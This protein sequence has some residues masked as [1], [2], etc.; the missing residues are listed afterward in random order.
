LGKKKRR[1]LVLGEEGKRGGTRKLAGGKEMH[2]SKFEYP[3][4]TSERDNF[5]IW[6]KKLPLAGRARQ[7][8]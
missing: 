5:W 7:E 8:K 6:V 4:L 2:C 3:I 1:K